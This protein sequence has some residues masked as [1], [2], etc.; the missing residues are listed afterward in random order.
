MIQPWHVPIVVTFA[1]VASELLLGTA[2]PNLNKPLARRLHQRLSGAQRVVISALVLMLATAA[3]VALFG[4]NTAGTVVGILGGLTSVFAFFILVLNQRGAGASSQPDPGQR[5]T[6]S[7]G[8][9]H[10]RTS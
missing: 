7:A 10:S 2:L 1:I 5:A 6:R 4:W 3:V 9:K 8:P